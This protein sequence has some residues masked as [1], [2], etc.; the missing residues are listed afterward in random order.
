[1]QAV[2]ACAGVTFRCVAAAYGVEIRR[3]RLVARSSF[4]ARGTLGTSPDVSVGVG[5][6]EVDITIDA[7]VDDAKLTRLIEATERYCVVGQSLLHPARVRVVR[8]NGS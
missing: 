8:A 2:V 1:M 4:D 7:D 5:E 6:V 3:A